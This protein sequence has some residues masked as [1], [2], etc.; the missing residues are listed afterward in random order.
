MEKITIFWHRRDL[1]VE[2]NTGLYYALEDQFPVLPVFIFDT[3]I[4]HDLKNRQDARVTFIYDQICSLHSVYHE[5]GSG[6]F[7]FFGTPEAAFSR[8]T[9]LYSVK[10]VYANRDYEPQAIARDEAV[11][12]LL[13]SAGAFFYSFKDQVIFERGEILT[14]QGEPYKVFTPFKNKWQTRLVRHMFELLPS[15]QQLK[16]LSKVPVPDLP[17]LDSMGFTRSSLQMPPAQLSDE[18]IQHYGA[19]RDYPSVEGTSRLGVHLRFGTVSIRQVVMRARALSEVWLNELIWREFYMMILAHFPRV[20]DQAFKPQ[21]DRIP[22]LNDPIH[23]QKWCDGLTGYPIVDAGMRELNA[24]GYMH[25]RVRMITASFL[26][27]HL[28]IDWRWGEHYFAETLLDY[29]LSSNNGGWQWA[30]GTGTDAQPYFRVFN[31]QSQQEKFDKEMKY[32][33]KW[34]PEYGTARY[35]DPMVDH[36]MAR[37]RA[38]ETYKQ[39]VS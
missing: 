3:T 25:N 16:K 35:P 24:T 36:K 31:P 6:L 27:K 21:Y 26:T 5:H 17:T 15:E 30:A 9:S 23:F 29:E 39:A 1:R 8:L 37:V 18:L 2:D 28:L 12:Q 14:D 20:V 19:V 34:V 38:I 33:R 7:V 11:Q 32:I 22:W 10:A 13:Q 4:L